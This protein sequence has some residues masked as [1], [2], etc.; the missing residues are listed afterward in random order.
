MDEDLRRLEG[1]YA[2]AR[3]AA[4]LLNLARALQRAGRASGALTV[5]R[6]APASLRRERLVREAEQG[7]W[8]ERLSTLGCVETAA[9][10]HH[11]DGWLFQALAR[12]ST[13]IP[14]LLDFQLGAWPPDLDRHP[15]SP[16]DDPA[17]R[18]RWT[19][20]EALAGLSLCAG[21]S[22][23]EADRAL[24]AARGIK[25]REVSRSQDGLSV[26]MHDTSRAFRL[27]LDA[28][29]GALDL[30]S[31]EGFCGEGDL[32]SLVAL[33]HPYA[34]VVGLWSPSDAGVGLRALELVGL[35]GLPVAQLPRG[36]APVAWVYETAL[37][38]LTPV[39]LRPSSKL[40]PGGDQAWRVEVWRPTD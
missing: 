20:G 14:R 12:R 37:L 23:T 32:G 15:L 16:P 28:E 5:L 33:W 11:D 18:V 19:P 30:D 35:T 13:A 3:D 38:V 29:T 26:R 27:A 1:D 24:L 31:F 21:D 34:D 39:E 2:R 22:V 6:G 17:E 8:R 10:F 36:A 25:P 40:V 4:T 9:T 7:L